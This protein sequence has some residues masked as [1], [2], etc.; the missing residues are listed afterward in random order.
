MR[1]ADLVGARGVR[2]RARG[3]ASGRALFAARSAFLQRSLGGLFALSLVGIPARA[4]EL[5]FTSADESR[6]EYDRTA[7][8]FF[9][10][11][12]VECHGEKNSEG[13]LDLTKLNPDMKASA[14]G[15]RWAMVIEKMQNGEMPPREKPQPSPESI[16]TTIRWA[17]AESKRAN[18]HFAKRASY[19]NGN[20]VPHASLFNPQ[21]VYHR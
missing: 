13:E 15:A 3:I 8:P 20:L 17:R 16:E 9:A 21:Q 1:K 7:K 10:K 6:A 5:K 18:K 4:D 12:C 19:E 2:G 11:H 14:D